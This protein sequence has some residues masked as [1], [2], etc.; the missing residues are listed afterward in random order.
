MHS[1]DGSPCNAKVRL[2]GGNAVGAANAT[3]RVALALRETVVQ[4]LQTGMPPA[5]STHV[6]VVSQSTI[7]TQPARIMAIVVSLA[8]APRGAAA[9]AGLT[10]IAS[11]GVSSGKTMFRS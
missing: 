6:D 8:D 1:G 10:E 9:N 2:A 7:D 5:I 4:V 11:S 3:W